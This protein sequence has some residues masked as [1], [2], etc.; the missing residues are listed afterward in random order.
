MPADQL[1]L[2]LLAMRDSLFSSFS[3]R[4]HSLAI[5]WAA[6]CVPDIA[7]I[8]SLTKISLNVWVDVRDRGRAWTEV[9]SRMK[10]LSIFELSVNANFHRDGVYTMMSSLPSLTILRIFYSCTN[11]AYLQ[12]ETGG[13]PSNVIIRLVRTHCAHYSSWI[14]WQV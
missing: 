8:E 6:P 13:S 10:N 7:V 11:D 3:G 9:V 4:L 2:E 14:S 12:S 5:A 1:K